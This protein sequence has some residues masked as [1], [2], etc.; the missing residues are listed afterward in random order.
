MRLQPLFT[1]RD[2]GRIFRVSGSTARR[3]MAVLRAREEKRL[4]SEELVD[5]TGGSRAYRIGANAVRIFGLTREEVDTYVDRQ[6]N[7]PV[8]SLLDEVDVKRISAG[9]WVSREV[10]FEDNYG[11]E[12]CV[13]RMCY[14]SLDG[15]YGDIY[16]KMKRIGVTVIPVAFFS[17]FSVVD[18]KGLFGNRKFIDRLCEVFYD[19][20][21]ALELVG[22]LS[23]MTG[24]RSPVSDIVLIDALGYGGI[25][26]REEAVNDLLKRLAKKIDRKRN[27]VFLGDDLLPEESGE[28]LGFPGFQRL[29]GTGFYISG[30]IEKFKEVR[31][32]IWYV[33]MC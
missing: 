10:W 15:E 16:S 24:R 29:E 17:W 27:L 9:K 3:R 12:F 4:G 25:D 11:K 2:I 8:F 22:Y 6:L 28:V 5:N 13:R 14:F 32:K 31:F 19:P 1:A 33:L 20:E 30:S 7:A 21:H 18:F 23:R 26:G